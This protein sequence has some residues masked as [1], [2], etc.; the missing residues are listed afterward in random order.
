MFQMPI[1]PYLRAVRLV[2]E[3]VPSANMYPFDLPFVDGLDLEFRTAVTFLVG[4]NGSG[5]STLI[6]AIAELCDLPSSGGSRSELASRTGP[7]QGAPLAAALRPSFRERPRDGYFFRAEH[8]SHFTELLDARR[9][10]PDFRG[11]P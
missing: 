4:E 1:A 9:E 6:E 2:P 3:R 5:K 11:D 8:M 7:D 10:D